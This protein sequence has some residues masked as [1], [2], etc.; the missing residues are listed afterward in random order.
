MAGRKTSYVNHGRQDFKRQPL[1][2]DESDRLVQACEDQWERT[3]I[4]LFMDTGVRVGEAARL[5]RQ[6]VQTQR[7]ELTVKNKRGPYGSKAPHRI[8]KMTP[9]V[10]TLLDAYFALHDALPSARS[11]ERLVKQV[12]GRAKISKPVTPHVLRHTFAVKMIRDGLDIR[13]LQLL[14]GHD[15]LDTTA[16]Y[17]NFSPDD[18]GEQYDRAKGIVT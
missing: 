18:L 14:L 8:V 10:A 12:A 17:L 7:R 3:V 6:D 13:S 2:E 1:T 16:I 11:L 15:H 5:T 9:K 4:G